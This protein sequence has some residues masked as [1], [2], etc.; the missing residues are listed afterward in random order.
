MCCLRLLQFIVVMFRAAAAAA[1]AAAATAAAAA[2]A[3]AAVLQSSLSVNCHYERLWLVTSK[4]LWPLATMEYSF[5][6]PGLIS[7]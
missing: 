1:A 3:A 5:P 2:A 6:R 4:V 7:L